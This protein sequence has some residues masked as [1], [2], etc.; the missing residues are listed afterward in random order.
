[1]RHSISTNLEVLHSQNLSILALMEKSCMTLYTQTPRN[2]NIKV[3]VKGFGASAL[4]MSEV[5]V[6]PLKI[7][8]QTPIMTYDKNVVLIL[9]VAIID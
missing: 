8:N 1:M 7:E 4:E 6:N 9:G 5:L 2:C 3:F